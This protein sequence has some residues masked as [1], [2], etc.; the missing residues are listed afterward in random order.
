MELAEKAGRTA[1]V[2]NSVFAFLRS[3]DPAVSWSDERRAYTLARIL[4]DDQNT[5][6]I[7]ATAL[8]RISNSEHLLQVA[9]W[10]A[11]ASPAEAA[12]VYVKAINAMIL[13]KTNRSY[14]SAVRA[15][16]EARPA[17][18]ADSSFAFDECVSRLRETHFRKRNFIAALDER[19]DSA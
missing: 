13:R 18:D 8:A 14:R 12:P 5:A 7:K 15:L 19:I 9:R 6:A 11:E 2:R 4:K 17:F 10:L 16:I 3:D 1:D